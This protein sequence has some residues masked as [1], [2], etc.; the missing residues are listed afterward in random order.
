MEERFK[1]LKKEEIIKIIKNEGKTE[2]FD[3]S[4]SNLSGSDLSWSN[5]SGSDLRLSNLR[6]SNLSGS[7]LSGSDLRL[8]DLSGSKITETTTFS[9]IKINKSQVEICLKEMF[10]IEED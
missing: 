5:L 7:D 4:W 2:K 1:K 6:L 8:S 3:L 9:K 10:E